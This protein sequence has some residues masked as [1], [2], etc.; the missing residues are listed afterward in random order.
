MYADRY[1]AFPLLDHRLEKP[2]HRHPVV[3]NLT[4]T[5]IALAGLGFGVVSKIAISPNYR[6]ASKGW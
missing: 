5:A 3:F 1:S 2:R 4:A 6:P